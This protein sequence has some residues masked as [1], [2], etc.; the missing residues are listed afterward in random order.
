MRHVENLK[1]RG[2]NV[3]QIARKIDL[4]VPYVHGIVRL[5]ETG[6][7]RLIREVERDRIPITVAITIASSDDEEIR[8]ALAE[9]Y[10]NKSLRGD[11]LKLVRR[12]IAQRK[13]QGKSLK[14][15]D[16]QKVNPKRVSAQSLVRVYKQETDRQNLLIRKA[17]ITQ[18]RMRIIV[19]GLKT[20]LRDEDFVTLLRAEGVDTLPKFLHDRMQAT[21]EV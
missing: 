18:N 20:L 12:I 13:G 6:E 5:L 14:R 4:D 19:S 2:H 16:Q 1:D 7:E 8:R 9:A 21:P 15:S 3:E 11:K 10:E 17:T